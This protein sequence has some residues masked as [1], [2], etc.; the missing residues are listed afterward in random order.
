MSGVNSFECVSQGR[1]IGHSLGGALAELDAVFFTLN[2]PSDITVVG[3]TFGTPRV[4]NP[5]WAD[6]VDSQVQ[7]SPPTVYQPC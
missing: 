5:D 6:L 3:R 1:Q 2:L 7:L 4:G